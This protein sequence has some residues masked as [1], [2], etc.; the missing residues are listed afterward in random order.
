MRYTRLG[1]RG[2]RTSVIGIGLW[3][4]GSRA[5]S[6]RQPETLQAIKDGIR[7]ALE[8]GINL[9]DTAE[10]YGAGLSERILGE[11]LRELKAREQAIIATKVAGF[12]WTERDIL[13]AAR[14]SI[15]RLGTKP[16]IIQ[17]HWP[18]PFYASIC[19]VARSLEKLVEEGLTSYIGLSNYPANLTA[20]ILECMKKHE[21]VSNQVQYNLAYRVV[22]HNLKPLLEKHGIALIAWSPL[23]K[24]AL[25]GKT[26]PS[27]I[28]QLLDPVFHAASKDTKLQETLERI[29]RSLGATKAEV[30]LAWLIAR[31]AIPIPGFRNP[32]HVDSAARAASITLSEEHVKALDEASRK[33]LYKWGTCYKALRLNRYIPSVLQKLV[34]LLGV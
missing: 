10:I 4:A 31:N 6:A 30:A 9:F 22:E 2:P 21:P 18:P 16:D 3:Q 13:K 28:A 8:H 25:A 34:A 33:Y 20:K 17:H 11:T 32:R 15:E 26:K 1:R 24:G 29:A 14:R 12:R 7:R 5:W 19:K 27:T 23:A